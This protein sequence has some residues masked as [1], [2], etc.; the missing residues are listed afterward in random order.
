VIVGG[1]TFGTFF[2]LLVVPTV[3]SYLVAGRGAPGDAWTE[4][5]VHETGAGGT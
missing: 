4:G 2:T 5:A 3:Y 1:M